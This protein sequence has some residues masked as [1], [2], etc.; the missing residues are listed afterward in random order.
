MVGVEANTGESSD[1]DVK[2]SRDVWSG[3]DNSTGIPAQHSDDDV[4]DDDDDNENDNGDDGTIFYL[5]STS[6]TKYLVELRPCRPRL[7]SGRPPT[8]HSPP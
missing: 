8:L 3:S 4:D 5:D 2:L 1:K 7:P 6:W